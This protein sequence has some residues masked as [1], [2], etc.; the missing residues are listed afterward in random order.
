MADNRRVA[1]GAAGGGETRV[2][3]FEATPL[4]DYVGT[5]VDNPYDYVNYRPL[6]APASAGFRSLPVPALPPVLAQIT[7]SKVR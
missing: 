5:I 6:D 3:G 1:P 7:L 2:A 4:C